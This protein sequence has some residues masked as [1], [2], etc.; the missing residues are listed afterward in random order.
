MT[1]AATARKFPISADGIWP[2]E[3]FTAAYLRS[4]GVSAEAVTELQIITAWLVA[5]KKLQAKLRDNLRKGLY[6]RIQNYFAW[7]LKSQVLPEDQ[8]TKDFSQ[9]IYQYCLQ[10]IQRYDPARGKT[11]VKYL[12]G[13]LNMY[14]GNDQKKIWSHSAGNKKCRKCRLDHK[15]DSYAVNIDPS[16][17]LAAKEIRDAMPADIRDVFLLALEHGLADE[18]KSKHFRDKVSKATG[19]PKHKVEELVAWVRRHC[20]DL[21]P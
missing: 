5:Y 13:H 15:H 17:G 19:V 18:F 6:Q 20:K 8:S 1:S 11:F 14:C 9:S 12:C 21:V 10:A 2:R 3:E 16:G 4:A 7:R